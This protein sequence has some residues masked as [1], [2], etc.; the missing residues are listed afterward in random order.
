MVASSAGWSF[1]VNGLDAQGMYKGCTR[2]WCHSIA[3]VL[4]G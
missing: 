3:R 4:K 1:N 2:D